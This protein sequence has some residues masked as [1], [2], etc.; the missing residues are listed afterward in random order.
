VLIPDPAVTPSPSV[1]RPVLV[2]GGAGTLG[3][4]VARI[5]E[6][7]GLPV[8]R[9]TRRELD[10]VDPAAVA[11]ALARYD[12][13]AVVNCAGYVRVDDAEADADRCR[14]ENVGGAEA[15][16][17]GCGRAGVRLATFSSDL[18]FDGR[19][20]RP[21]REHDPVAPLCVYGATKAE[22]ERRVLAL[23]PGALVVRTGAFFGP[24]DGA[25]FVHHA[26][27]ALRGGAVFAA[28]DDLT[29]TPT[30]VPDLAHATLDLLIDGASG[31]WHLS[32]PDPVTWA[33][34]ARRA[35]GLAGLDA[36]RV[37][38]R[39]AAAFGWPARRPAYSAL[40]TARGL[41]LPPLADGLARYL[42][43]CD[44]RPAA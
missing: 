41:A 42:R 30:Y 15:L 36:D 31:V 14:R 23:D 18:V 10:A 40:G 29:V 34:L 13:W 28:A 27:T 9:L 35:A 20:G 37:T 5:C 6:L 26:L 4:A 1:G 3:R 39:P 22:A 17:A 43:E 2:T 44:P 38:G 24:W 7:R 25:N 32:A 33:D 19:A 11:A 16:A 8:V 12:P 21:Y